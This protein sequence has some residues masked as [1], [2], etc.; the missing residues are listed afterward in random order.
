MVWSP[1]GVTGPPCAGLLPSKGCRSFPAVR[2]GHAR[3][4]LVFPP[5]LSRRQSWSGSLVFPHRVP[6]FEGFS[7]H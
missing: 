4:S 1:F 6:L 7:F 3:W 5:G 2:A